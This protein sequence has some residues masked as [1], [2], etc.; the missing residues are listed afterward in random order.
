MPWVIEQLRERSG[1]GH[2]CR[3][4]NGGFVLLPKEFSRRFRCPIA[5]L[6]MAHADKKPE[7]LVGVPGSNQEWRVAPFAELV[8][9]LGCVV[10]ASKCTDLH[11]ECGSWR[12]RPPSWCGWLEGFCCWFSR[13]RLCCT[14]TCF[15]TALRSCGK[16]VRIRGMHLFQS[17]IR[18]VGGTLIVC[19]VSRLL[20][21]R[22]RLI[23]RLRSSWGGIGLLQSRVRF[24]SDTLIFGVVSNSLVRC[25]GLIIRLRSD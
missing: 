4:G 1:L 5:I 6:V 14:G 12:F 15:F 18:F 21:Q 9:K 10:F 13:R 8:D 7:S 16:G 22:L 20:G 19:V 24:V 2:A 3:S 17:Q 11:L 23:I 25:L